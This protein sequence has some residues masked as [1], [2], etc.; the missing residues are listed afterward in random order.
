VR[1]ATPARTPGTVMFEFR[2]EPGKEQRVRLSRAE[3]AVL[4]VVS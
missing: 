4:A 2:A 1:A 3:T